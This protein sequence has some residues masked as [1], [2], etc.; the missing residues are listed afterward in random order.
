MHKVPFG[1]REIHSNVSA[2]YKN[3]S[4]FSTTWTDD[5]AGRT[6]LKWEI[7]KRLWSLEQM[8]SHVTLTQETTVLVQFETKH[9]SISE[10]NQVGFVPKLCQK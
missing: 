8:V 3:H 1:V 9:Q 7:A 5:I 4:Q 2:M 10:P 6:F